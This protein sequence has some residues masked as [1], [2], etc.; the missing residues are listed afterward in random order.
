MPNNKCDQSPFSRE[1]PTTEYSN[2]VIKQYAR[3]NPV[4]SCRPDSGPG[5]NAEPPNLS[6]S[7]SL[8]HKNNQLSS[9]G[10]SA[11]LCHASQ[12]AELLTPTSPNIRTPHFRVTL[13]RRPFTLQS[14]VS[15]LRSW[16]CGAADY[17]YNTGALYHVVK[18]YMSLM[19]IT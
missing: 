19:T 9:F 17:T 2:H 11:N 6:V 3:V 10:Y 12:L 18:R 1:G 13:V 5:S 15:A 14:F 16:L 8:S 7:S 4:G